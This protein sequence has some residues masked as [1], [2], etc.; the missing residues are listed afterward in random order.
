MKD[1]QPVLPSVFVLAAENARLRDVLTQI[2]DMIEDAPMDT[3]AWALVT[4]VCSV[5]RGALADDGQKA[6][7]VV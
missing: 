1:K 7:W 6:R 5:A 4:T 3:D 2:G